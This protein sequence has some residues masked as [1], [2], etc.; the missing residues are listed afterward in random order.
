MELLY[1]LGALDDKGRLTTPLGEQMSELPIAPTL[2]K[3]LFNAGEFKKY[4]F[5]ISPS[6]QWKARSSFLGLDCSTSFFH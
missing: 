1:A 3:M 5:E 4:S 2:S 6:R